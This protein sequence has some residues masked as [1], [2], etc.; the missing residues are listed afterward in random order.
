MIPD[1]QVWATQPSPAEAEATLPRETLWRFTLVHSY[2][3]KNV[4]SIEE[5]SAMI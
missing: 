2:R 5:E 1:S 3:Q 4:S